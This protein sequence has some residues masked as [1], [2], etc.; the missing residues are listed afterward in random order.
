MLPSGIVE[1]GCRPGDLVFGGVELCIPQPGGQIWP[2]QLGTRV[3]RRLCRCL[4]IILDTEHLDIAFPLVDDIDVVKRAYLG[5]IGMSGDLRNICLVRR[6]VFYYIG[7]Y[8]ALR[9][10]KII[11]LIDHGIAVHSIIDGLQR[12]LLY[13][14]NI[15][16]VMARLWI[17]IHHRCHPCQQRSL[18]RQRGYIFVVIFACCHRHNPFGCLGLIAH[19]ENGAAQ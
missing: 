7:R 10:L 4:G 9:H 16:V 11:G 15:I 18:L 8:D 12:H 17:T 14:L 2:H 13:Y 3:C 19:S 5:G 1:A 6:E